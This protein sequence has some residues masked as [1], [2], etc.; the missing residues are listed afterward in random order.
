MKLA[1]LSNFGPYPLYGGSTGGS[2]IVIQQISE[3]LIKDYSYIVDVY[4]YNYKKHSIHN[5]INLFPCFK[6]DKFINQISNKYDHIFCYSDSFWGYEDLVRSIDK[7]GCKLTVVLVG[8]YYTI[9][10]PDILKVLKENI[11]KFNLI[12]HSSITLDYQF[13]IDNNLPVSVISNGICQKEFNSNSI[14]FREKYNIKSQYII[15]NISSFF[16][17]KNQIILPAGR[18]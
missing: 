4:A 7:L 10:H 9:S 5:N 15:L 17:G 11:H 13:C 8:A 12:T 16:Y 2:E 1:I 14:N 3:R 6:G 18:H